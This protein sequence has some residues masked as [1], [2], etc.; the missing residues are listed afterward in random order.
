MFLGSLA[1]SCANANPYNQFPTPYVTALPPVIS[2]AAATRHIRADLKPMK[3]DLDLSNAMKLVPSDPAQN[4]T[5]NSAVQTS[6]FTLGTYG[7]STALAA[8]G[9]AGTLP[10]NV[11][12]VWS[13]DQSFI[14]FASNRSVTVVN[15]QTVIGTTAGSLYHLYAIDAPGDA[16]SLT[17]LTPQS[18]LNSSQR[19]PAFEG[20]TPGSAGQIVFGQSSTATGDYTLYSAALSESGGY[21][22]SSVVSIPTPFGPSQTTL[23]VQHPTFNG[24]VVV[25]SGAPVGSNAARHLY[26]VTVNGSG[27]VSELTYD[28][29]NNGTSELDPALDPS[30][31]FIAFDSTSSGWAVNGSGQ[32]TSAGPASNRAVFVMNLSGSRWSQ[33][34]VPTTTTPN[35]SITP[36]W[37]YSTTNSFLNPDG[38]HEYIFFSSYRPQASS[39][40]HIYYLRA[41]P[42]TDDSL[43]PVVSSNYPSHLKAV[44]ANENPANNSNEDANGAN[45]VVEVD[46]SDPVDANPYYSQSQIPATIGTSTPP[47]YNHF[48]PSVSAL[49]NY[50]MV[51]YASDRFLS[52]NSFDNPVNGLVRYSGSPSAPVDTHI[53]NGPDNYPTGTA[54]FSGEVP[55]TATSSSAGEGNNLEL[56][57][58]RL[59]NTDPPTLLRY[60]ESTA[61]IFRMESYGA[62]GTPTKYVV[63]GSK[64]NIVVRL[65]DRESGVGQVYLQL[66]DPD[67]KYQDAGGLEHKVFTKTALELNNK[68]EYTFNDGRHP[69]MKPVSGSGPDYTEN[70]EA[71]IYGS[72]MTGP[73]GL[74]LATSEGGGGLSAS[75]RPVYLGSAYCTKMYTGDDV[76]TAAQSDQLKADAAKGATQITTVGQVLQPGDSVAI[77]APNPNGYTLLQTALVAT[78][79]YPNGANP[80]NTVTLWDPLASA[81]AAPG[82]TSGNPIVTLYRVYQRAI[83]WMG[84][85]IDCQVL[86]IA[87]GNKP[88][89]SGSIATS[90]VVDAAQPTDLTT[91]DCTSPY[92]YLVPT[93]APALSDEDFWSG[94]PVGGPAVTNPGYWIPLYPLQT[95][96]SG[97]APGSGTTATLTVSSI[98]GFRQGDICILT[99]QDGSVSDYVKVSANPGYTASS[100]QTAGFGTI[101]V[102]FTTAGFAHVGSYGAGATL[103]EKQSVGGGVL[104]MT[105]LTTPATASDYY[106]DLVAFD[107]SKFP[108][109]YLTGSSYSGVPSGRTDLST[110]A[111]LNWRIYDNVEGFTTATFSPSHE[112]LVVSDHTLPQ[113][114]FTDR[115]G[116]ITS[117]GALANVPEKVYGAESYVTDIDTNFDDTT[118][119]SLPFLDSAGNA[120]VDSYNDIITLR[121]PASL[122]DYGVTVAAH[123]DYAVN[124]PIIS[125]LIDSTNGNAG[126]AG[127]Y[128]GVMA[129]ET[130]A[131]AY[132]NGLGVNSYVDVQDEYL[133]QFYMA[134][135][136]TVPRNVPSF[137]EPFGNVYDDVTATSNETSKL[138]SP[139]V[140][141]QRYDIWRILCRGGVPTSVLTAYQPKVATQPMPDPNAVGIVTG[142]VTLPATA[143]LT[144]ITVTAGGIS[145][146]ATAVTGSSTSYTYSLNNVPDGAV[147]VYAVANGYATGTASVSV[148]TNTS[149]T[150]PAIA[151][152]AGT[153]TPAAPYKAG[154]NVVVANAC[155]LW[156][157][158]YTGDEF[159]ETG[160]MADGTTQ[161]NLAAFLDAGGRLLVEGQDVGNSLTSGGTAANNFYTGANYLNAAAFDSDTS[162]GA[163]TAYT[164]TNST[165]APHFIAHDAFVNGGH[166]GY[167]RSDEAPASAAFNYA[168]PDTF[169]SVLS[170]EYYQ[171]H[172][173]AGI[174]GYSDGSLNTWANSQ[175]NVSYLDEFTAGATASVEIT[176]AG[177]G[178]TSG[179]V[180]LIYTGNPLANFLGNGVSNPEPAHIAVY[181]SFGLEA[182]SQDIQTG[183]AVARNVYEVMN[184]RT[185]LLHNVVC[186]L[187]TGRII[188]TVTNSATG[189]Q[190]VPGATVIASLNPS[191]TIGS[192]NS[193]NVSYTALTDSNGNYEIDGV[194]AGLYSVVG[195]AEVGYQSSYTKSPTYTPYIHGGDQQTVSF[196]INTPVLNVSFSVT[197]SST[198]N[199]VNGATVTLYSSTDTGENRPL[200]TAIT[201]STG[202]ATLTGVVPGTYIVVVSA[203]SYLAFD[204]S[205]LATPNYY[206][207]ETSGYYAGTVA[208]PTA[209]SLST[210]TF[211]PMPV[212]IT[213]GPEISFTFA[214]TDAGTGQAL[215]DSDNFQ[216]TIGGATYGSDGTGTGHTTTIQLKQGSYPFTVTA[217]GY[218]AY[219]GTVTISTGF[220]K[221]NNS[222]AESPFPV[223]IGMSQTTT[224]TGTTATIYGLVTS[225]STWYWPDHGIVGIDPTRAGLGVVNKTAAPTFTLT[226]SNNNPVQGATLT[227]PAAGEESYTNAGVTGSGNFNYEISGIPYTSTGT[228]YTL[229][230]TA[231]DLRSSSA[232]VSVTVSGPTAVNQ[233]VAITPAY[234]TTSFSGFSVVPDPNYPTS[235]VNA[236]SLQM[237]TLPFDFTDNLSLTDRFGGAFGVTTLSLSQPN[238][239]QEIAVWNGSSQSWTEPTGTARGSGFWVRLQDPF[240]MPSPFV[241]ANIAVQGTYTPM[242]NEPSPASISLSPGWNMIGNPWEQAVYAEHITVVDANNNAS[243]WATAV[244]PTIQ[245]LSSTLFNFNPSAYSYEPVMLDTTGADSVGLTPFVGYWVYA[246]GACTLQ[247]P[248]PAS[249][250]SG[251]TKRS[252]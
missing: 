86:N 246:Y 215:P 211:S 137:S 88:G 102:T 183:P 156:V 12:P 135:L 134:G 153:S 184:Q 43:D 104:Y 166:T 149:V 108:V 210:V 171:G 213:L 190:P 234:D 158:P 231:P 173:L 107:N 232:P 42:S 146:T 224:T 236:Y 126:F 130:F 41:D 73:N 113:K 106:M 142:T 164:L 69:H 53:D 237:L 101:G 6:D 120:Y 241:S 61:E 97:V 14:I 242:A 214:L 23:S 129:D 162:S 144:A 205:K 221:L 212:P 68:G 26:A 35:I 4:S 89:A 20:T 227:T 174:D 181:S 92:N 32:F 50:P 140:D 117:S 100:G 229:T 34:T 94:D 154:N 182:I 127:T 252:L 84:N 90:S 5:F 132:A 27:A 58:S 248:N 216:V 245:L 25:F 13:P 31:N 179:A 37:S 228:T 67:S 209:A 203:P 30:G 51:V 194:P 44:V 55:G 128:N 70:D 240:S 75:G 78:V 76:T 157:T 187:R 131:P 170:N 160:S 247:I 81:I 112:I 219:S 251:A 110:D 202:L 223:A 62:Q 46:S 22:L 116:T 147:T 218:G 180:Q 191:E 249:S 2:N 150:A 91:F 159:V 74:Q 40:Y 66:K 207:F 109:P 11:D 111:A 119:T 47:E 139:I 121:P 103:F 15:G 77:V 48:S 96:I 172:G 16:N 87:N 18:L 198:N 123:A 71:T 1:A 167:Q 145:T 85:E 220:Y 59:F 10:T 56:S 39:T 163:E 9:Q 175:N 19:Y 152:A 118:Y 98:S 225:N 136:Y 244:S 169:P 24:N 64:L 82:S 185:F 196:V 233:D 143:T 197:D 186:A 155:V 52:N 28:L 60:D 80:T 99:S 201:N 138:G 114:F 65:S 168:S 189:G 199:A 195:V 79:S 7:L 188:G 33:L 29:A 148:T 36:A 230:I 63:P 83:D 38:A 238:V 206:T 243:T 165:G 124:N 93:Y 133:N 161:A 8:S 17:L 176:G 222:T 178:G 151:L 192:I 115:F 72:G 125:P 177:P 122:P 226:D 217:S 105:T 3:A 250:Q 208:E 235:T 141:S 193:Q 204:S 49:T 239:P 45:V 95:T 57:V 54:M 21:S 200:Y